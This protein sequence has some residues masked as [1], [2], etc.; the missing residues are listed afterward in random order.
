VTVLDLDDLGDLLA[1]PHRECRQHCSL[2]PAMQA[3]DDKGRE[4]IRAAFATPKEQMQ[5]E[6]LARRLTR[7]GLDI[8]GLTVSRHRDGKCGCCKS[9]GTLG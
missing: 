3:L 1:S 8:T 7:R 5:H 6:E 4:V 2:Y 9:H